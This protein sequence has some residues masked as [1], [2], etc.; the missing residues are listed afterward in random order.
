MKYPIFQ[1]GSRFQN[2]G[3]DLP[4]FELAGFSLLIYH[5]SVQQIHG[6]IVQFV[7]KTPK[8]VQTFISRY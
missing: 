8:L 5:I 3:L 6:K 4:Y 2:G 1:N 7:V